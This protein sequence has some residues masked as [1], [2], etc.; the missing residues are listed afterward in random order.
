M[1]HSEEMAFDVLSIIHIYS[2]RMY[3]KRASERRKIELDDSTLQRIHELRQAGISYQQ[4]VKILKEEGIK[5]KNN[6]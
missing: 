1:S 6:E 4:I 5:N 2:C 3:G